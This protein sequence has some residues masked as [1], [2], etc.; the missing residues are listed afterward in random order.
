[1]NPDILARLD[2]LQTLE[3]LN[4][5]IYPNIRGIIGRIH[6]SSTAP[7]P[8]HRPSGASGPGRLNPPSNALAP[9][10][11]N[12]SPENSPSGVNAA[13]PSHRRGRGPH[14]LEV[15]REPIDSHCLDVAC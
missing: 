7:H 10:Q 14:F 1:M 2:Q 8:E 6:E 15:P 13:G 4:Q 12:T 9:P 5:G 3:R 11:T